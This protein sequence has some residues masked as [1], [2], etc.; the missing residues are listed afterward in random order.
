M[1][2]WQKDIS[3]ERLNAMSGGTMLEMTQT[4]FN[5]IGDDFLCATMPVVDAVRQPM[6]L[7]HGGASAALAESVGS[8]AG[9]F[10]CPEHCYVLGTE[11]TANHLRSVREGTVVAKAGPIHLG[12]LVQL[13]QIDIR[14]QLQQRLICSA[15]LS[16][17]VRHH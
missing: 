3:L 1:S 13:W 2:I 5:E 17:M 16:L 7:L 9:F 14:E 11:I 4:C 15:R 12:G 8:V 6:G 10:A